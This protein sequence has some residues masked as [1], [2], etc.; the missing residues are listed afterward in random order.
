MYRDGQP[1]SRNFCFLNSSSI[2]F[3]TVGLH[4][5]RCR[6]A[7]NGSALSRPTFVRVLNIFMFLKF[8]QHRIQCD[9]TMA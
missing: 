2:A 6:H 8:F 9:R 4:K 5:V 7:G 3:R 1:L